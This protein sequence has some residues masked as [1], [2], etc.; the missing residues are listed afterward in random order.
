MLSC[1]AWDEL[2]QKPSGSKGTW[3]ELVWGLETYGAGGECKA[4]LWTWLCSW[5]RKRRDPR[6]LSL[7]MLPVPVCRAGAAG[8]SGWLW[9][10]AMWGSPGVQPPWL[11]QPHGWP[12]CSHTGGECRDIQ[13]GT[14]TP[15]EAGR[16]GYLTLV[17][18]A[19]SVP[20]VNHF[21]PAAALSSGGWANGCSHSAARLIRGESLGHTPPLLPPRLLPLPR[22]WKGNEGSDFCIRRVISNVWDTWIF[23]LK[24]INMHMHPLTGVT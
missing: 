13:A 8:G 18:K 15:R 17:T 1:K 12:N 16:G 23:Q 24:W 21:E 4:P 20:S 10:T 22:Q 19:P 14:C 11:G 9:C 2:L 6:Q 5:R 7:C 3:R